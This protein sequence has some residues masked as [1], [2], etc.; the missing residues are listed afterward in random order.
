MRC[1]VA[2]H[3][4]Q[5]LTPEILVHHLTA[6]EPQG[7]LG[8]VALGEE[9]GEITQLD[10]V[11]RLARA[12]AKLHFL[13]L[14][15]LLLAL[16]GVGFLVLLEQE[17]PVIHDAHDRRLCGRRYLD[18]IELRGGG[19]LQSV[20]T[21]HHPGLRPI[22]RDHTQLRRVDLLVAPDPL[23]CTSDSSTL[24]TPAPAAFELDAE[25]FGERLRGHRAQILAASS[26]H[27]K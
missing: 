12:G 6:A 5:E 16:G 15:L 27:C 8:L 9:A 23:Y 2:R 13:Y 1:E 19:H 14:N 21:R 25:P 10:L 22:G 20:V 24:H 26:A 11:I 7:Y 3:P 18:Q 4:V 17:L